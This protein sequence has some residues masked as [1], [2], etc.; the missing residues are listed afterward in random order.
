MKLFFIAS[1]AL[2]FGGKFIKN[3][4]THIVD[5]LLVLGMRIA[6][7]PSLPYAYNVCDCHGNPFPRTVQVRKVACFYLVVRDVIGDG[8][9][10]DV[11]CSS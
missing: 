5:S 4:N 2:Y 8:V 1:Q 10:K 7:P 9:I 11:K 6:I 3:L